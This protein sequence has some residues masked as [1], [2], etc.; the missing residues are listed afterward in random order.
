MHAKK[1]TVVGILLVSMFASL[2]A[3]SPSVKAACPQTEEPK[4]QTV[5]CGP[6]AKPMRI[7]FRHIEPN[8]IGYNQGY[9]TAEGF[10]SLYNGWEDWILFL[11]ARMHVFNNGEPALNAG[12][13]TRYLS[14]SRV[15]GLNAYYDYRKTHRYHYNQITA[16]LES[17]GQTWDFR[18]NGY[19]PVGRW[20]SPLYG[21]TFAYFQENYAILRQ[22]YEYALG[23]FNAEAAAHVDAW[24]HFPL[25]FAAGPYFLRGKGASV[26]GGQARASVAIYDYLKIEGNVSYDHL[27]K[28][29]GQGQVGLTFSFGG[30]KKTKSNTRNCSGAPAL[31]ERAYQPVDRFEIIPVDKRHKYS[32]AINPATGQPYFFTFVNNL[33]SSLGTY[34]SPYATLATAEANSGP[35][36]VIYVF[37]GNGTSTG[38]SSGITLKPYQKFWGSVVAQNLPTTIGNLTIPAQS[39][40]GIVQGVIIAPVIAHSS[41]TTVITAASGNEISGFCVQNL[42]GSSTAIVANDT[43]DLTVLNCLIGGPGSVPY[44]GIGV[45]NLAGTLTVNNCTIYE[46]YGVSISNTSTNL[47]ANISNSN[48]NQST[49][50]A[51]YWLY[52]G[53]VQGTLTV[54]NCAINSTG[55]SIYIDQIAGSSM[56]AT[57]NNNQI[58]S[59]GNGLYMLGAS[60]SSQTLSMNGNTIASQDQPVYIIQTDSVSATLTNN[61]LISTS[62]GYSFE[63]DSNA[64]STNAALNLTGNTLVSQFGG[65]VYFL[66]AA[67]NITASLEDNTITPY[68]GGIGVTIVMETSASNCTLSFNDNT[69]TPGEYGISVT[70]EIGNFTATCNNNTINALYEGYGIS[71]TVEDTSASHTFTL[72]D[73]TVAGSYYSVYLDQSAG[74]VDLTLNNNVLSSGSDDYTVYCHLTGGTSSQMTIDGNTLTGYYPV[75]VEQVGSTACNLSFTNNTSLAGYYGLYA[76]V[77]F[78]TSNTFTVSGNTLAGAMPIYIEQDTGDFTLVMTDNTLSATVGPAYFYTPSGTCTST[79]TISWNTMISSGNPTSSPDGIAIYLDA[80]GTPDL[81]IEITGNT[82]SSTSYAVDSSFVGGTQ[83]LDVSNNIVTNS[84]GIDLDM[85]AGTATWR[86]SGNQLTAINTTAVTATASGGTVCLILNDNAVYPTSADSAYVLTGTGSTFTLNTPTG[87]TGNTN[88]EQ[89]NAPTGTCE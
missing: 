40:G 32:T 21:S 20:S 87:N 74:A 56:T 22:R 18:I 39:S 6:G 64:G 82:L 85:T 48:F 10:F 43:T 24:E 65:S 3:D 52:E 84:G 71:L 38:M 33:S 80:T 79:Q 28:W 36:G 67:G 27:F 30:R 12:L 88:I 2:Q 41:D 68:D 16:G 63:L 47:V 86:V 54:E 66:Q 60:T 35:Y 55:D 49:Y 37:P 69:I 7:S 76:N 61:A 78:G 25:Y 26:W 19:A 77:D 11:D 50:G 45:E 51:V 31:A 57:L 83:T 58:V 15:W 14:A 8:G 42:G 17:L 72:N 13:G 70:Q 5:C 44:A 46:T 4:Q 89:T 29:I 75:Y 81:N 62:E 23:G 53:A 59:T 34:E 1:V 73:S 9:T